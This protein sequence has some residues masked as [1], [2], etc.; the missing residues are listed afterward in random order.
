MNI[1]I[2]SLTHWSTRQKCQRDRYPHTTQKKLIIII[3]ILLLNLGYKNKLFNKY[4]LYKIVDEHCSTIVIN[5][6]NHNN[7]KK[8]RESGGDSSY[9]RL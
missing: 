9:V 4:V 8:E 7:N 2:L 5:N 3:I 6:N 1:I